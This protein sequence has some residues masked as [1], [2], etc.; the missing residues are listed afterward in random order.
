MEIIF[1]L[2]R[3]LGKSLSPSEFVL[4]LVIIALTCGFVITSF[5]KSSKNKHGL[6]SFLSWGK[7]S[8]EAELT[9]DDI[10]DQLSAFATA[11][12]KSAT[13]MLTE[14]AQ[15]KMGNSDWHESV[16][17]AL[18]GVA[19]FETD[20][21]NEI[22]EIQAVLEKHILDTTN[23]RENRSALLERDTADARAS[24]SGALTSLRS[25]DQQLEQLDD[26]VRD[27]TQELK[28]DNK[29]F[30][31]TLNELSKDVALIERSIQSH[32]GA[33]SSINLR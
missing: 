6:L 22:Y 13:K 8:E 17:V 23:D 14:I 21:R 33:N 4:I 5:L 31:K 32:V 28:L 1:N 20:I 2:L 30:S 15:I 29:E 25:I 26:Y 12:T 11:S 27:K 10:R 9:L 18:T 16:S 19:R 7:E 24:L 3:D